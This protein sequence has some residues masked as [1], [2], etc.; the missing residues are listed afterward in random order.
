M[1]TPSKGKYNSHRRHKERGIWLGEYIGIGTA[2][3]RRSIINYAEMKRGPEG[4]RAK[5]MNK[6]RCSVGAGTSVEP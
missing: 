6:N 5:K 4:Q 2:V 3:G 1:N